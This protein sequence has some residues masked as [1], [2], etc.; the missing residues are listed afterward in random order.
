MWVLT[1]SLCVLFNFNIFFEHFQN[2]T[3][4]IFNLLK[5]NMPP[6]AYAEPSAKL[7]KGAIAQ[8]LEQVE[9]D[10]AK[11]SSEGIEVSVT[12]PKTKFDR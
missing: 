10:G 7:P 1:L 9:V 12:P 4:Q 8:S 11:S 3:I 2:L 6:K 5:F